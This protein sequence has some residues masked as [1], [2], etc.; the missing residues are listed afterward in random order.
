MFIFTLDDIVGVI[1][2][3]CFL[4][5]VAYT[6]VENRRLEKWRKNT[7]LAKNDKKKVEQQEKDNSTVFGVIFLIILFLAWVYAHN[8]GL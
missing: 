1:L 7:F 4:I 3:I 8:N 2:I 6:F 5:F